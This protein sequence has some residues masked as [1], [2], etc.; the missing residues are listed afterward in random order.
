MLA[1]LF[2]E[3][4]S[5]KKNHLIAPNTG[6]LGGNWYVKELRILGEGAER[7][8]MSRGKAAGGGEWS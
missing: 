6:S 7:R 8:G 5:S 2:I 3:K 4:D 1:L